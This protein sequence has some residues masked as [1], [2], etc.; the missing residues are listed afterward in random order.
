MFLK[1]VVVVIMI[2]VPQWRGE[3]VENLRARQGQARDPLPTTHPLQTTTKN[4][5]F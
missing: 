4:K 3:G 2:D 1:R 5:G